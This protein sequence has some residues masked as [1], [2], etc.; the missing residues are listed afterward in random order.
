M[1]SKVGNGSPICL[2]GIKAESDSVPCVH[3]D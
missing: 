3:T 2:T 1:S